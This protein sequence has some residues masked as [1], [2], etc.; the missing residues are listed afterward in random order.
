MHDDSDAS[1][2]GPIGAVARAAGHTLPTIA[3]LGRRRANNLARAECLISRANPKRAPTHGASN[4]PFRHGIDRCHNERSQRCS[5]APLM[6]VACMA[7]GK[8]NQRFPVA[9]RDGRRITIGSNPDNPSGK[10]A[11]TSCRRHCGIAAANPRGKHGLHTLPDVDITR[12]LGISVATMPA[13]SA[14]T[15]I[16]TG[17]YRI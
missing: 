6:R 1:L 5:A 16:V 3:T 11:R 2:S 17:R 9:R 14:D 8:P 13:I 15:D 4:I 10:H 7:I 12:A